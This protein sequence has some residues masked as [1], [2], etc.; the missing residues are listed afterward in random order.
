M[1]VAAYGIAAIVVLAGAMLSV[2]DRHDRETFLSVVA[3]LSAVLAGVGIVVGAFFRAV[4]AGDIRRRRDRRTLAG[5]ADAVTILAPALVRTGVLTV[6]LFT[7]A[8]WAST[9]S[10]TQRPTAAGP[11][12][13]DLLQN[14]LERGAV[15][16]L[17]R[18][19]DQRRGPG[20][21]RRRSGGVCWCTR[22]AS[23]PGPHPQHHLHQAADQAVPRSLVLAYCLLDPL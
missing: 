10:S 11:G 6:V 2:T 16:P 4:C 7:G 19:D 23:G 5:R 17:S 9:T 22:P 8:P 3:G 20:S 13:A 18:H 21:G 12:D 1:R 14:R 15:R